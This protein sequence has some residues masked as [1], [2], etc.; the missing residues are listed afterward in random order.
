MGRSG[1][2]VAAT[3]LVVVALAACNRNPPKTQSPATGAAPTS[4]ASSATLESDDGQWT[5]AA[6]D[7]ANTRYSGLQ[8]ITTAN[9]KNLRLA[10]S[11]SLYALDLTKPGAPVKWAYKPK[12]AAGS[13]ASA[14]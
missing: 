7:Y 9:A 2:Q 6:R 11:F 12:P 8:E 3:V 13:A 4:P 14:R 10:W 1:Y 5:M